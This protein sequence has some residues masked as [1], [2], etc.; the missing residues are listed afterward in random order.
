MNTFLKI[1]VVIQIITLG[2]WFYVMLSTKS[3]FNKKSNRLIEN[4]KEGGNIIFVFTVIG[5]LVISYALTRA[6]LYLNFLEQ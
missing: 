4:W 2:Y 3:T 1:Y 6:Y 5:S